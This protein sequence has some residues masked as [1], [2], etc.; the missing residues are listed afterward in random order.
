MMRWEM[1]VPLEAIASQGKWCCMPFSHTNIQLHTDT[2]PTPESRPPSRCRKTEDYYH[3]TY[4]DHNEYAHK[5]LPHTQRASFQAVEALLLGRGIMMM[6]LMIMTAAAPAMLE[7]TVKRGFWIHHFRGRAGDDGMAIAMPHDVAVFR[8]RNA[9]SSRFNE[10][11][12]G[13]V[14]FHG[15]LAWGVLRCS[16]YRRLVKAKTLEL[17]VKI[18]PEAAAAAG[19]VA[20]SD[21]RKLLEYDG[22]RVS[23]GSRFSLSKDMKSS[24]SSSLLILVIDCGSL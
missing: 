17:R 16:C 13:V 24:K 4:P 12:N 20:E 1:Q 23:S 22:L 11:C 15:W 14:D 5:Y 2:S 9:I 18:L 8:R 6:I 19:L 3:K 7:A 10:R 21:V